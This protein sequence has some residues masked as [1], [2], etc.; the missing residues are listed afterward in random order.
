MSLGNSMYQEPRDGQGQT[1]VIPLG[2]GR[3]AAL[4]QITLDQLEDRDSAVPSLD[5][6]LRLVEILRAKIA[7]Y[8]VLHT[9]LTHSLA[10]ESA[11]DDAALV[12]VQTTLED[13]AATLMGISTYPQEELRG[14]ADR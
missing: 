4:L 12:W 1:R 8:T 13:V 14:S 2:T 6:I 7:H 10:V 11:H 9:N 5:D 3:M